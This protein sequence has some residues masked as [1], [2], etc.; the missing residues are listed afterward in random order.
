MNQVLLLHD[1]ATLH[2]SLH[3]TEAFPTMEWTVLP[4]PPC[5]PDLAPFDFHIFGPLKDAVQRRCSAHATE[6]KHSMHENSQH[7]SKQ[8]YAASILHLTQRW[9]VD[10]EGDFVEI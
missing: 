9:S 10:N 5:C 8:Y 3:T 2:T 7:F 6:L 4:H 1:S